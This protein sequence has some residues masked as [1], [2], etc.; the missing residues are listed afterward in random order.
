MSPGGV[1]EEEEEEEK[2][3]GKK[4]HVEEAK[5][6]ETYSYREEKKQDLSSTFLR[7]EK[8]GEEEE[9]MDAVV[10]WGRGE[11]DEGSKKQT[12]FTSAKKYNY[13]KLQQDSPFPRS[14]F[15][16]ELN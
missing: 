8:N 4:G 3:E 14:L 2:K 9:C 1:E 11:Q 7:H 15:S 5:K 16:N 12:S 10:D 6:K 13:C